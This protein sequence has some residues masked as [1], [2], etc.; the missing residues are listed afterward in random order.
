[1][2]T[3]ICSNFLLLVRL[4]YSTGR[5]TCGDRTKQH[6]VAFVHECKSSTL[7]EIWT[8]TNIARIPRYELVSA[9]PTWI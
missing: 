5:D 7:L 8:C 3:K 9:T 1:M 4:F 6:H 2:Q